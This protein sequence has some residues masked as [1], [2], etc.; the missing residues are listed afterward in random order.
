M[1][2]GD[3]R[4]SEDAEIKKSFDAV[5]YAIDNN[6]KTM[7]LSVGQLTTGVTIPE[8]IAAGSA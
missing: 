7:T 6:E 1:A 8:W 2:A 3:G 5:R 4:R